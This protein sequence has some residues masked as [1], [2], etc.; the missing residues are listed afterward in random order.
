[1]TPGYAQLYRVEHQFYVDYPTASGRYYW[2]NGCYLLS[3]NYP[4]TSD[5]NWNVIVDST[6]AVQTDD[7]TRNV[8][9]AITIIGIPY[10]PS[11]FTVLNLGDLVGDGEYSLLN[12]ALLYGSCD[13]GSRWYRRLRS[14]LRE[15]DIDGENLSDDYYDLV[16]DNYV[17]PMSAIPL[18]NWR[19]QLITS[20]NLDR[21]LHKWQLRHGSDRSARPVIVS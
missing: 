2:T 8:L 1:M 15:A 17:T 5:P 21:R 7:C 10:G 12:C 18:A 13:D 9:Q 4:P 3:N 14:P 20:W 6:L 19:G 11:P 16:M